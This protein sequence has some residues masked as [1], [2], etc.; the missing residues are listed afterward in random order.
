MKN[1]FKGKVALITGGSSGIGLATARL[2]SQQGA[3][4]WLVARNHDRLQSAL[5]QVESIRNS[6][7]Q[8]CGM[9]TA[10]VSKTGE[11]EKAVTEVI[12]AC[13]APDILINCA[14][15]VY[16]DLFQDAN[17]DT[18]RGLME[19]D[20]FG[21]VYTTKAC[22]PSMIARRSGY[23]VNISS[24]Y[25]FLGGYGYSAYCASKFAVRGFSD[26]IRAE[27]K[28]LGIGVSV[29]FPQNTA[30]PQLERE[31]KLRSPVMNALDTTKVISAEEVARAIVRGIARR[32]YI[33]LCGTEAKFLFWLTGISGSLIYRIMD[34]TVASAQKK[35]KRTGK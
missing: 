23:I 9:V 21:T 3:H 22:L 14:G 19:V 26:A 24:V 6:T 32:Q 30:T 13:G 11:A 2:L 28:P 33:I 16:P 5:S 18:V 15:D 34:W 17:L 31:I 12:R 20:Y 29:V 8:F 1:Q 25:G 4:V 10:D 7:D 27:L 35:V